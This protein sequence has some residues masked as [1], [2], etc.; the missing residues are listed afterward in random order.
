MNG[1]T[2]RVIV[3]RGDSC[4]TQHMISSV[5]SYLNDSFVVSI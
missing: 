4:E 2:L 1:I 3:A 5:V